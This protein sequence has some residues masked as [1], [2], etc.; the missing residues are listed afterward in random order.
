M[1][2]ECKFIYFF[3]KNILNTYGLTGKLRMDL[4]N[5]LRDRYIL[6]YDSQ[7]CNVYDDRML[8]DTGQY[9]SG[10]SKPGSVYN[11]SLL[12]ILGDSLV[13]CL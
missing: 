2:S 7:Q 8:R 5:I 3:I 1:Q 13:G 4:Q 9:I 6:D 12:C 10:W 11:R